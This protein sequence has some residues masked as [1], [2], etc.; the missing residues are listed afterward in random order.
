MDILVQFHHV[1]QI[2]LELLNTSFILLYSLILCLGVGLQLTNSLRI[3]LISSL[4]L[5]RIVFWLWLFTFSFMCGLILL[6][7]TECL[8]KLSIL[9]LQLF[10]SWVFV[11]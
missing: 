4:K 2:L 7:L 5:L 9:S 10:C 3:I 6:E 8:L 1:P 11:H